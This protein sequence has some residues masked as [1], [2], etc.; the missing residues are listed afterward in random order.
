MAILRLTTPQL[1]GDTY[2]STLDGS[3][4]EIQWRWNSRSSRWWMR[5]SDDDG[6]ICYIP[7]VAGFPLL[8]SVTGTRRPPGEIIVRDLLDQDREPGLR[9]F[10]TDF[11][12]LYIESSEIPEGY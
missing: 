10:S 4:Y 1:H 11:A 6:Q 5:L 2:T 3:D 12:V 8:R 9:D 7:A